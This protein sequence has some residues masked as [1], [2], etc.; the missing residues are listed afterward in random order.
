[1]FAFIK[2]IT[3]LLLKDGQAIVVRISK[4][5]LKAGIYREDLFLNSIGV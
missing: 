3:V 2:L 5:G 1:M 4:T